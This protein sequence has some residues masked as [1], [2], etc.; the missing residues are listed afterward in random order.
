MSSE[1]PTLSLL[2]RV[3]QGD[4]E[5]LDLVLKEHLPEVRAYVR[6][7]M[8]Q[9]L[10]NKAESVD[11]VQ[12]AVAEF[13]RFGPKVEIQDPEHLRAL[14]CKIALNVLRGKHD[15][16]NAQRRRIA[17]ESP[18]PEDSVLSL[19]AD[20]STPSSIVNR[21]DEEA[22]VRLGIELLRPEDREVILLKEFEGL[23]FGEVADRMQVT[24]E[25]AKK[26]FQRALP[27]L[28]STVTMLRRGKLPD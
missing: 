25:T 24:V 3:N 28:A 9:A 20:M 16:F 19:S 18:L 5:A 17:R 12:D 23:S 22:W 14:L 11:I 1:P 6:K 21:R 7:A 15:Y 8:G 10:S 27:R 4:P 13:L 2:R 26:R